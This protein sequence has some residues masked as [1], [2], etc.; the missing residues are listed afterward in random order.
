[1]TTTALPSYQ[2]I[3]T[4][5]FFVV[6][7]EET[8]AMEFWYDF[9]PFVD[10]SPFVDIEVSRKEKDLVVS[11]M[12]NGEVLLS[13]TFGVTEDDVWDGVIEKGVMIITCGPSG[14]LS[15]RKASLN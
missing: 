9:S 13:R 10:V 11:F 8:G 3:E 7:N 1:M 15:R 6:E 2:T 4:E 12:E 14:V 5:S